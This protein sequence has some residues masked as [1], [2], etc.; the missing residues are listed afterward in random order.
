LN[1]GSAKLAAPGQQV[2]EPPASL[3]Q[4]LDVICDRFGAAVKADAST[5]IEDF[6]KERPGTARDFRR[7]VVQNR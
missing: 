7:S 1:F 2:A 6:L 3:Q 5:R 4:Q